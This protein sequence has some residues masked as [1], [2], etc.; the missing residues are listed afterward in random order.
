VKG[1]NEPN[2]CIEGHPPVH[3]LTDG[4]NEEQANSDY[5]KD[6]EDRDFEDEGAGTRSWVRG[7]LH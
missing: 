3:A 4:L 6:N 2:R 5:G 7:L 1:F